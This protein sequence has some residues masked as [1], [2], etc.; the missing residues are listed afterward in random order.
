MNDFM[1]GLKYTWNWHT[2][3]EFFGFSLWFIFIA[4]CLFCGGLLIHFCITFIFER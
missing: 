2:V 1:R 4:F 3:G